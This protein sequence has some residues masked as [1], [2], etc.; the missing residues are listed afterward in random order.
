MLTLTISTCRIKTQT[1]HGLLGTGRRMAGRQG[2]AGTVRTGPRRVDSP[3]RSPSPLPSR[4]S[5]NT[6][7][8]VFLEARRQE[9]LCKPM[10]GQNPRLTR[11]LSAMYHRG[12]ARS[13]F[14]VPGPV[15]LRLFVSVNPFH[16]RH[17]C[18]NPEIQR[19]GPSMVANCLTARGEDRQYGT[20]TNRFAKNRAV[21][22][23]HQ[24]IEKS[25]HF[26]A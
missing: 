15:Y 26:A 20:P 17:V 7:L 21:F 6:L 19:A 18:E 4:R 23:S 22:L 12:E 5:E 11:G 3:R 16:A 24:T 1:N 2:G 9:T 13:S 8:G 14:L 10:G 25:I